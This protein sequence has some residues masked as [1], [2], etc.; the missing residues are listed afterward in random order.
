MSNFAVI[1]LAAGMGKRMNSELPK[2]MHPLKGKPL[3]FWVIDQARGA[4]GNPISVV[5]GHKKEIVIEAVK[6]MNVN[7]AVQVE[8]KGTA[9]AVQSAENTLMGFEGD[10]LILSGDVPLLKPDTIS[11]AYKLHRSSNSSCTVFT[12]KPDSPF[13]YGRIVRNVGNTV[14]AIVE[15][16]D[17]SKDI[18][19]IR[20]VNAG[21]YFYK[22]SDLWN[23]IPLIKNDNA[24]REFYLT[25]TVS[26]LCEKG[27]LVVPF[28]VADPLETTG[29]NTQQQLNELEELL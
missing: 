11:E 26:M 5:V 6:E 23:T 13:G 8:Q 14:Q 24:S 15:E 22:S 28:L 12:F 27:K 9:N 20:E 1:I 21:I 17:A 7:I 29:I 3:L 10:I 2:V 18:K 4:G 25:D 19:E 16:K